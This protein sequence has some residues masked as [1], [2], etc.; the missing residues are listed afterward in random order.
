MIQ[1]LVKFLKN[2][3]WR[4]RYRNIPQYPHLPPQV[5]FQIKREIRQG[6]MEIDTNVE[7][8]SCSIIHQALNDFYLDHYAKV[9][10]EDLETMIQAFLKSYRQHSNANYW[11]SGFN[12]IPKTEWDSL[13]AGPRLVIRSNRVHAWFDYLKTQFINQ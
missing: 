13:G 4:I 6:W 8:P 2:L 3:Y 12:D 10:R 11:C 5:L 7:K 1:K 9:D